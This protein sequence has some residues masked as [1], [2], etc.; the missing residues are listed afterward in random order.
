SSAA[1]R[2][3]I[4]RETAGVQAGL[5][6]SSQLVFYDNNHYTTVA[7]AKS[8]GAAI[9]GVAS[10]ESLEELPSQR[11]YPKID[12]NLE[13]HWQEAKENDKRDEFACQVRKQG[14]ELKL[15]TLIF[16]CEV[17]DQILIYTTI[18]KP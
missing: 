12:M 13:V 14:D 1:L 17:S 6:L 8:L 4:A 16:S 5:I 18:N 2:A 10:V 7:K 3:V 15:A 11:I 9:A